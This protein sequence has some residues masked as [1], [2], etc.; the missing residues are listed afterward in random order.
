MHEPRHFPVYFGVGAST[1]ATDT[2]CWL[3][4]GVR[5][6]RKAIRYI[7]LLMLIVGLVL[8]I[9]GSL[10]NQ[11]ALN[12]FLTLLNHGG[13]KAFLGGVLLVIVAIVL[14]FMSL[15]VRRAKPKQQ[16]YPAQQPVQQPAQ[17]PRVEIPPVEE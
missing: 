4:R 9:Y 10:I 14:L 5:I 12:T 7:A 13:F 6:M 16:S 17:Q 11:V 1:I 8:I 2:N 15:F 3:N